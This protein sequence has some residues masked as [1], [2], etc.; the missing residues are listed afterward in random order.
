MQNSEQGTLK[1]RG[2]Q[3]WFHV[4]TLV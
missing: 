2:L 1:I 4:F 3:I